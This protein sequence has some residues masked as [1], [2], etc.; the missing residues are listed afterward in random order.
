VNLGLRMQSFLNVAVWVWL[1]EI[2]PLHMR[3]LGI[4]IAVFFGRATNGFLALFFPALVEGIRI[5]G[6]FFR[7]PGCLGGAAQCAGP[8]IPG[9]RCLR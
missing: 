6:V 7:F 4:G 9:L 8:P 5:N 2:F 3:G 1:A